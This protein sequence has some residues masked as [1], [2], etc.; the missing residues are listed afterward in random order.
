MC[1][2]TRL[3]KDECPSSVPIT[4]KRK[5]SHR[6]ANMEKNPYIHKL[7]SS[8]AVLGTLLPIRVVPRGEDL[9]MRHR[10]SI[11]FLAEVTVPAVLVRG[12]YRQGPGTRALLRTRWK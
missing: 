3:A 9:A 7:L 12:R 10:P 6:A 2:L 1:T 5:H 4:L 8:L 11:F